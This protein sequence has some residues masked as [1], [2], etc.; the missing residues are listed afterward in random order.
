MWAIS[1]DEPDS[2]R[3][4]RDREDVGFE[5]LLDPQGRTFIAYGILNERSERT[6]PHP[7]VIVVDSDRVARYVVSDEDYKVRPSAQH[8]SPIRMMT[9]EM[10]VGCKSLHIATVGIHDIDLGVPIAP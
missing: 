8:L 2:L 9:V 4:F 3:A 10:V 7:T 1:G 6:V 5:F